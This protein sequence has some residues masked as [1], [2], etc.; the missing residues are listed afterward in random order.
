M[1]AR[2]LG[3]PALL[4]AVVLLAGCGGARSVGQSGA[5]G[6]DGITAGGDLRTE[7]STQA[8]PAITRLVI[9]SDA[10]DLQLR[11]GPDGAAEVTRVLR[12]TGEARP[13]VTEE[14][15]ADTLRVTARCPDRLDGEQ[16]SVDFRVTLPAAAAVEATVGA[17][18]VTVRDLGG[19]QRLTSSAGKVA[20]TGLR[21]AEA[22]VETSAG[23]VDVEFATAPRTVEAQSSAGDVR[24]ALPAGDA[25][26]VDAD[27]GAG[28]V[29]V[30]VAQDPAAGRT[31][32]ARTSAGDVTI[33][34]R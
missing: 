23:D 6:A 9:D 33:E 20:A 11:S 5:D 2:A 10:G 22:R 7:T 30:D 17:G 28:D 15:D 4:V 18:D 16:C 19:A 27:T 12:W 1:I 26:R 32:T 31:V 13:E 29:T 3:I 34:P 21:A 14:V 24:V 25:Y 8:H